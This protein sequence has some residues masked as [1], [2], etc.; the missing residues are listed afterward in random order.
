MSA[1]T[2]REPSSA[3]DRVAILQLAGRF[4][5]AGSV[6]QLWEN[7]RAG[8]ESISFF[9]AA[10]LAAAGVPAELIR[11]P[12][13]VPAKGVIEGVE[14][15]DARLFG[16]SAREAAATDPQHRL[17]LECAFELLEAAGYGQEEQRG[18][19]G[20]F[21]GAEHSGYLS[22]DPYDRPAS[23]GWSRDY[24]ASRLSY[25]LNLRGPSLTV[26]TACSTSLVAVHLACRSLLEGECDLAIAGGASLLLPVRRGHLHQAGGIHSPDGHCRTFDARARG[27]V[28]GDGV[29]VVLLKRLDEA[30]VAGDS[31]RA[32]ILG[33]AINNDGAGKVGFAAPSVEGQ[34]RVIGEALAMAQVTADEIGYVE[35]HGTGTE[36]GDPIEVAA[37]TQAFRISTSRCGFCA[38][39][40]VK[41]N[42]GHLGIAAGATG[43]IKAVLALERELIPPSLHFHTP[44]PH[45]DLAASPFY[46]AARPLPWPRGLAPRRAG[47]SSFGIGGTN[48]H[49]IVEESPAAAAGSPRAAPANER[50]LLPLSAR[51]ATALAAAASRLAVHLRRRGDLDL[52]EVACTLQLGRRSFEHRRVVAGS[53]L[54]GAIEALEARAPA[55]TEGKA[56]GGAAAVVFLF[57]GQG[58]LLPGTGSG[59]YRRESV[60][61]REID[62][63]CE[64]LEP[65]LG[66]DLRQDLFAPQGDAAAA[67]RLARTEL[68]QP[69]LFVLEV[70]LARLWMSW[71]VQ[72]AAVLGHSV[73]ELAAA[74][75]A[76]V[77]RREEALELVTARAAMMQRL[78]AG[79][80]LAVPLAEHDVTPALGPGLALAAVN[81]PDR[82]VVA[83]SVPAVAALAE[84]LGRRGVACRRL[85]AAQAFHSPS[86]G[87]AISPLAERA[88]Q[89]PA[90]PPRLPWM[91]SVT[92][93]WMPVAA[94]VDPEYWVRQA[95]EPVRFAAAVEQLAAAPDR[96]Y[97]EVGP[98]DALRRFVVQTLRRRPAAGA[99]RPA[100]IASLPKVARADEETAAFLD[101]AGRLW[102]AGVRLDWRVFHPA[103]RRPAVLPTYPFERQA[104]WRELEAPRPHAAP[105]ATDA[106]AGDGCAAAA[107]DRRDGEDL[108]LITHQLAL[109]SRQLDLLETATGHRSQPGRPDD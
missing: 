71:G 66:C 76:G 85:P 58:E 67:R 89:L 19:V 91:S 9:T 57:P 23:F 56:A 38:L 82:C 75:L 97:L 62:C 6:E 79:A 21:L 98:G 64:L 27:T 51:T 36:L 104:Y 7:L 12:T 55:G 45:L 90:S 40:S 4:P 31:I 103:P 15:F 11:Q 44:N 39:G 74:H 46:V 41:T 92:G 96:I 30:L 101:A 47:V 60:F 72:P 52:A 35:A 43:L 16:M 5:G 102:V 109:L 78:P 24:L 29:A 94:P 22:W 84:S 80:M 77:F 54:A 32:V 81:A 73:G 34:R 83:G 53:D 8:V 28:G 48:A 50:F 95:S 59:L 87:A 1:A 13:Y 2:G 25:R 65:A 93:T 18:P 70:A 20:V 10:E 61:R 14:L 33:S 63:C 3:A 88:R 107:G 105:A 42:V 49:V 68:A 100:A 106:A 17:L 99:R 69:A 108:A 86:V 37:L 26:Q